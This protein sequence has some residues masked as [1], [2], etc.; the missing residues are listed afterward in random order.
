MLEV[1]QRF[2]QN[3]KSGCWSFCIRYITNTGLG[4]G[5]GKVDYRQVLSNSEFAVFSRLREIRKM[6][7]LDDGVPAYAVFTD[8]ELA[9]VARLPE[10]TE[11]TISSIPGIGEKKIARYGKQMLKQYNQEN[12]ANSAEIL[13]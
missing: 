11:S 13:E 5:K 10:L 2:F 9:G 4:N 6:L 1:E 12:T 8:E 7:A 3:E